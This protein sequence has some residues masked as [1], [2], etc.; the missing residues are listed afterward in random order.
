MPSRLLVRL[1]RLVLR[2]VRGLDR[3]G[4]APPAGELPATRGPILAGCLV[5][6]LFFGG[7]V[8]WAGSVPLASAGFAPGTVTFAGFRKTVQHLEGGIVREILVADGD[9]VEAGQVLIRLDDTRSRAELAAVDAQLVAVRAQEARLSAEQ[10]AELEI[11][12]PRA[13]LERAGEPL[14][15][16]ALESQRELLR[17]RAA[18]QEGQEA[19]LRQRIA[20]LREQ[21]RGLEGEMA[22]HARELE[23]LRQELEGLRPLAQRGV[24]AKSRLWALERQEAQLEGGMA[25]NRAAI[26]AAEQSVGELEL[27]IREL[28]VQRAAEVAHELRTVQERRHALES[29]AASARDTFERTAVR[30][31][32][33]GTVVD[34]RVHTPG[35]VLAPGSPVLDIVPAGERLIVEARV[36]PKDRDVVAAGQAASVRFTAFSQ[37]IASTV[38]ARVQAI[39]ADSLVDARTGARYYRAL[40]ELTEDPSPALGGARLHPGMQADVMIVT[41]ERTA[42]AYLARPILASVQR[43]LRED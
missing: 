7:L 12:F 37:R 38:A 14:V 8:G 21:I 22:A 30:A 5:L 25:E 20:L 27:K 29:Q 41:G 43:A 33:A 24:V 36:D 16:L 11:A 23:I 34:R 26:A 17:A 35:G 31:P 9:E 42:L 39:S 13:L 6:A 1:R 19:I 18:A 40:V 2:A 10:K 32:I 3:L 15:A 28:A 4:A